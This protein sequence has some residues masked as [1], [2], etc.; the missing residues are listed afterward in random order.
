MALCDELQHFE[1]TRRQR[2]QIRVA[3]IVIEL[4]TARRMMDMILDARS[5]RPFASGQ[6][7]DTGSQI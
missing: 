4:P 3:L 5:E 2:C 6:T 7:L 1:F